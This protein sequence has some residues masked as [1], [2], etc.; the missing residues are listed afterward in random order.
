MKE[1]KGKMAVEIIPGNQS[2]E[3]TTKTNHKGQDQKLQPDHSQQQHVDQRRQQEEL[4]R[5][6]EQQRRQQQRQLRRQQRR[7]QR[8]QQQQLVDLLL[9]PLHLPNPNLL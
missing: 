7:Q 8:Q 3:K 4:R 9:H 1:K 2:G 6:D 5:H